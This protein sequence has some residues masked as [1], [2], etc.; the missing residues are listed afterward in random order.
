MVPD[1][2]VRRPWQHGTA[3]ACE[4]DGLRS[5]TLLC[6]DTQLAR[7]RLTPAAR[8]EL[9]SAF[10]H[11]RRHICLDRSQNRAPTSP[12]AAMESTGPI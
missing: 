1:T 9:Y 4:L 11:V 10:Q 3:L 6:Q 2:G 5:Y 8:Q 12:M 7:R